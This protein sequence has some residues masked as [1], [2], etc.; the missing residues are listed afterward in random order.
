[1]KQL[2]GVAMIIGKKQLIAEAELEN[3]RAQVLDSDNI[4]DLD[5]V[6]GLLKSV[7]DLVTNVLICSR[8]DERPP[9]TMPS[10]DSSRTD[11]FVR[12]EAQEVEAGNSD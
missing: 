7:A 11:T 4:D 6:Q 8:D 3:C 10:P 2:E 5:V 1:V 12:E 9:S